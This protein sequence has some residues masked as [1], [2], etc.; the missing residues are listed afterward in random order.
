MTDLPTDVA[1]KMAYIAER[2][3]Y[4]SDWCDEAADEIARLRA[5]CEALRADAERYMWL[6][7]ARRL[8][9]G[10]I[11]CDRHKKGW[12]YVIAD[13]R[14]SVPRHI[15]TLDAAIDAA[16]KGSEG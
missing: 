8:Y 13:I 3:E 10:P 6:K 2:G 16:R 4:Y 14:S 11:V 9:L 5:E 1:A 15:D 12:R 7:D